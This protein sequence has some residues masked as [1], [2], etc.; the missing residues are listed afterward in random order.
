VGYF[1]KAALGT[2]STDNTHPEENADEAPPN[3]TT[4]GSD[5]VGKGE[6]EWVPHAFSG[7]D[8]LGPRAFGLS[9]ASPDDSEP[10]KAAKNARAPRE[11]ATL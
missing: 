9:G 1:L 3:P 7:S 10:P 11:L 2:P 8:S 4:K 6:T 5:E